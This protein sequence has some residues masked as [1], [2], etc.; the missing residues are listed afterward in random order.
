MLGLI[1]FSSCEI[2]KNIEGNGKV[3]TKRRNTSSF[4]EINING[5][6][7]V[8]LKQGDLYK[9]EVITDENLQQIVE[10][11][12]RGNTLYI[13]QKRVLSTMPRGWMSI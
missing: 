6:L 8:Y 2:E 3:I 4:T 13:K 1:F 12:K 9:V 11:E 5:V 10:T 7:D